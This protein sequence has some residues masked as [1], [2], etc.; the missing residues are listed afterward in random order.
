MSKV[1]SILFDLDG[2]LVDADEWHCEA[3]NRALQHYGL[4]ITKEQ[5]IYFF[6]ALS[7][8][9]K[10]EILSIRYGLPREYHQEIN[11][12]KQRYTFDIIKDKCQPQPEKLAMLEYLHKRYRVAVC[13]NSRR[14]TVKLMLE[15]SDLLDYF[16]F[17]LSNEDVSSPKPSPE[18]YFS[19]MS[20]MGLNPEECLI[21]EDSETGL[22]AAQNCG[23]HICKVSEPSEVN[24][25]KIMTSLKNVGKIKVIIPMAGEG[26]RFSRA[27]YIDPKPMIRVFG[28]PMIQWVVENMNLDNSY[29]IFLC[30][31]NHL[32]EYK[33]SSYLKSLRPNSSIVTVDKLTEGAACTVL[34]AED[35]LT[36]HDELII[37]N[38]D[39]YIDASVADFVDKMRY[40]NAD[41]GIITF[42][43]SESKWSYAEAD[44]TGL[45]KRVAEKQPISNHATVGIY[46]YKRACEFA[47]FAKSMIAKNI[48][49][50]N[51]FYVCPIF[52]EYIEAGKSVYIH[53][54]DRSQMHGLGTP[55]DLDEFM[56]VK[57]SH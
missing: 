54:I 44:E 1:A 36:D 5:H 43:A 46:Y 52:N 20:K 48:R 16:E 35:Y 22:Q 40:L 47:K 3:L 29:F 15:K 19:A 57:S 30:R 51:E 55:E 24:L 18:I 25:E 42:D 31:K 12:L 33:L 50:N 14:E 27:G 28:K 2:V 39:Q 13:S 56:K 23:A 4:T 11:D 9:T 26:S 41:A 32:E 21:V 45:V 53:N 37:A 34:L 6:K 8:K 7:T 49:T 17:Y 38:S 10:L